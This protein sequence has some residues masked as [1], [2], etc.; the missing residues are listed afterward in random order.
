MELYPEWHWEALY[1][2]GTTV[3]QD[4]HKIRDID[5]SRLK[6]FS[7]VH[8]EHPPK[9]L[10]WRPHTKLIHFIRTRIIMPG[11]KS[12]RLYCF[13]YENEDGTNKNIMVIT[14]DGGLVHTDS[15]DRV[16]VHI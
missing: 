1:T 9:V 6:T 2:D 8:K 15:V 5:L 4:D 16:Q 3:V 14:P 10:V 12:I 13:G 11:N 7:M